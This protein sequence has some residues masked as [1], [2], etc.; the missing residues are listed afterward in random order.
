MSKWLPIES[1]PVSVLGSGAV[2]EMLMWVADGGM[3][4]SGRVERGVI[5][6][7]EGGKTVHVYGY[8]GSFSVT[9]WMPLPEPPE[10][11]E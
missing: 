8:L 6:E 7:V 1:A 10:A 9:H 3:D 5:Y 2:N 11:E 4:K